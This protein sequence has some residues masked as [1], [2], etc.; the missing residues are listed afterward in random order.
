MRLPAAGAAAPPRQALDAARNASWIWSLLP[1]L[2]RIW[3]AIHALR[4]AS[5]G[6]FTMFLFDRA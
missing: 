4:D 6:D 1:R 5:R 2:P 3:P